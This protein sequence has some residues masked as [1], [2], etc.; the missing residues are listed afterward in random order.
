MITCKESCRA[1]IWIKRFLNSVPVLEFYDPAA[2]SSGWLGWVLSQERRPLCVVSWVR[3]TSRCYMAHCWESAGCPDLTLD[4][5]CPGPSQVWFETSLLW[6]RCCGS[7]KP[8]YHLQEWPAGLQFDH[9]MPKIWNWHQEGAL[10]IAR[11]VAKTSSP[12][13]VAPILQRIR[14]MC[15]GMPFKDIKRFS[16]NRKSWTAR[17][18]KGRT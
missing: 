4:S 2:G 17:A 18:R 8:P 10:D 12:F 16:R 7:F 14:E 3:G 1:D 11:L 15:W 13:K 6:L 5:F 9:W